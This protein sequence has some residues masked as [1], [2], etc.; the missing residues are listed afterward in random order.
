MEKA[1]NTEYNPKLKRLIMQV[2]E[3]QLSAENTP[4]VRDTY[5]RLLAA[6]H[7]DAGIRNLI[8]CALVGEIYDVMKNNQPFNEEKYRKALEKLR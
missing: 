6:G 4:Y 1:G 8:G 2:I 5:G 7:S 3:N